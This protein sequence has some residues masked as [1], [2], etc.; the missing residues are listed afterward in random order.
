MA[1]LNPLA[2]LLLL[3]MPGGVIFLRWR[4]AVYLKRLQMLRPNLAENQSLQ[5]RRGRLGL[6]GMC[7][8]LI[9]IAL[10]R[11]V[12]GTEIEPVETQGVS[13]VFVLD[14][15]KSMDAEDIQ[16]S[17]LERAKLSLQELLTQLSGN[18]M[19]LILFAGHA[20]VQFPL[21]TDTLSTADFVRNVSTG[22][23]SEQGTNI[24]DAIRMA[25]LLLKSASKGKHLIVLL[26]DGEG[27]EG[28]ITPVVAEAA[29]EDITIFTIGYGDTAGALIPIRN[30]DGSIVDKTDS[31]GNR[32][33]SALDE[34]TLK[35]IAN[36]SGGAYQHATTDR[37]E[38][39]SLMRSINQY[40]PE[41][42]NRGVQSKPVE[43]F[44]IFLALAI[45]L[46]TIEI[47]LPIARQ[48]AA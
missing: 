17:R 47:V 20:V 15:S 11:P 19:G 37:S 36:A 18:E 13:I 30:S 29:Q 41:T 48:Q 10:A 46:L 8:I 40:V 1:F 7:C 23:I 33:V 25:I 28:N 3:L 14:I 22:T 31:A 2:L 32:V 39:I 5:W 42:L 21:T 26:T 12:W 38:V 24:P 44:D 4:E 9:I 27:H 6:W 16:P 35:A 45:V 34:T 43:R